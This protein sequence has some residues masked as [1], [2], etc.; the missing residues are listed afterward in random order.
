MLET[1]LVGPTSGTSRLHESPQNKEFSAFQTRVQGMYSDKDSLDKSKESNGKNS[2]EGSTKNENSLNGSPQQ[3]SGR[4]MFHSS[5][6]DPTKLGW[7][8]DNTGCDMIPD[9]STEEHPS[10]SQ[11]LTPSK[12]GVHTPYSMKWNRV[13]EATKNNKRSFDSPN[14]INK[15]CMPV[16][17]VPSIVQAQPMGTTQASNQDFD[18]YKYIGRK[19]YKS[20]QSWHSKD[21]YFAEMHRSLT[22]ARMATSSSPRNN[23]AA[24]SASPLVQKS[25][26]NSIKNF[27]RVIMLDLDETLVRAEPLSYTKKY[28]QVINVKVAEDQFQNFGVMVRPYTTEFLQAICQNHKIVVYTASVQE[29]AEKIVQVLDPHRQFIDQV[30]SREHCSFVGGLFVKNLEIGI[31]HDI[32]LENIIIVDNYVHSY[33]LHLEQGIPIK[34]FYGDMTDK[35]LLMLTDLLH[36]SAHYPRFLDFMRQHV[37]FACFY[38]FLEAN[39]V[40]FQ[41]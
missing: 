12:N 36:Q 4:N 38:E 34:P 39:F 17:N 15:Y 21:K 28:S 23:T 1:G 27:S 19:E 18:I 30:L 6:P 13:T 20:D 32:T 10:P 29:Y 35:E 31:H 3:S 14:P 26:R 41:V 9:E 2:M 11:K 25:R 16:S 33:A 8:F 24:P 22:F 7:L 5:N 37:D 40:D